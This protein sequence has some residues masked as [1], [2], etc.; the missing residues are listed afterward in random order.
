MYACTCEP[1]GLATIHA[2][3]N[4]PRWHWPLPRPSAKSLRRRA[5]TQAQHAANRDSRAPRPGDAEPNAALRPPEPRVGATRLSPTTKVRNFFPTQEPP[6]K[7]CQALYLLKR[8]IAS[9]FISTKLRT[10]VVPRA[11]C[12]RL[13][14]APA[15]RGEGFGSDRSQATCKTIPTV[16]SRWL[17]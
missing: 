2:H 5:V 7:W 17:Y 10:F 3:K 15:G 11:G 9:T 8:R 13:R 16:I 12:R 14:H 6:R 1:R 4:G